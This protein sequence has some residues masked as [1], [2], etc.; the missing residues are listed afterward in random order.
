MAESAPYDLK[1]HIRSI[2]DFPKPGILFR[3]ITP[4]LGSAE[5]FRETIRQMADAVRDLGIQQI[6]T[7]V[8]LTIYD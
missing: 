7:V 6:M 5:A 2:P 3:D 4:L 1:A 8:P